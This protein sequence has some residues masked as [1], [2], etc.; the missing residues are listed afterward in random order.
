MEMCVDNWELTLQRFRALGGVAE[1]VVLGEGE[2]G[3][4]LF[5]KDPNQPIKMSIPNHL[6]CRT[7][8]LEFDAEGNLILTDDCDWNDDTKAFYL[9]YQRNYGISGSLMQEMMVQQSEVFKLPEAIK[10]M[11]IGYGVDKCILQKPSAQVCL[12]LYKSSRRIFF[13]D[14][15]VFMPLVELVNHDER[16]KKTFDKIPNIAINGK[17]KGEILVHYG[18]AGDAALMFEVYGFSAPKP[19]SFSGALAINVGNMVV[20]IARFVNLYTK[21]EKLYIPK[22]KIEGNIIHLSFLVLGSINDKSSPK[23]I[24]IKLMHSVGMPA[25]IASNV[26]DGIVEHNKNFFL[27]LLEEL[28]PLEG[29]VVEGL[30]TMAKHQLIPL[31]VRV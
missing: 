15:L 8:W 10:S 6:L 9:V 30:R 26:F 12:E 1:N 7:E 21:I 24:F 5:P 22:L 4:G 31:G 17:F 23:K 14:Q 11:L 29:S 16:S 20:K 25:N 18:M 27:H 19:Y 3:R 2:F 13:T 28:K